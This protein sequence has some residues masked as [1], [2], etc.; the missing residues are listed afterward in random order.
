LPTLQACTPGR[1]C[2]EAIVD[3]VLQVFRHSV[4]SHELALVM[5]HALKGT[6]AWKK[7]LKGIRDELKGIDVA[8]PELD[9]GIDTR[10]DILKG[11][12]DELE[13]VDVAKP[14]LDMGTDAW[15]DILRGVL[16]LEGIDI[17]K[18]E[19]DM[20]IDMRKDIL[21]SILELEGVDIAKLELD[22]GIND[23]LHQA[24]D[25]LTQVESI[26]ETRLLSLFRGQHP[27]KQ[28]VNKWQCQRVKIAHFTGFKFIL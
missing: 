19:L 1:T 23:K 12:R 24:Q 28:I 27:I 16:E 7:M 25:L 3:E 15:K 6:N 10:K 8:K 18:P 13:G 20:G 11:I 26:P 2:I 9:M 17:A 22:M 4:L 14:K 21:K 5:V